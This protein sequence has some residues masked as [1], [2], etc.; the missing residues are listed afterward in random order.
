MKFTL[1]PRHYTFDKTKAAPDNLAM[2]EP[3][4]VKRKLGVVRKAKLK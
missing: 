1:H 3:H 2:E 4:P